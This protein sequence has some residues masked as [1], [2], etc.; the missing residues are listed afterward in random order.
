MC[1]KRDGHWCPSKNGSRGAR[2]GRS[3]DRW[4]CPQSTYVL[5][6]E[7]R[8]CEGKPCAACE[9]R[10]EGC[11]YGEPSWVE[12]PAS[13]AAIGDDADGVCAHGGP[14]G[15][16]VEDCARGRGDCAACCGSE[17]GGE[18][19]DNGLSVTW[20]GRGEQGKVSKR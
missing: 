5:A 18:G 9:A 7:G 10:A 3:K 13:E 1:G 6:R 19:V 20:G 4:K 16:V 2:T 11:A 17:G 12:R 14:P 15:A 8:L